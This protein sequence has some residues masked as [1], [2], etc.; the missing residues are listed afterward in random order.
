MSPKF[1]PYRP[2]YDLVA[3][4]AFSCGFY[5]VIHNGDL[6]A[7]SSSEFKLY[8]NPTNLPSGVSG[9]VFVQT[10]MVDKN[11]GFQELTVLSQNGETFK[12]MLYGGT[13]RAWK[14]VT[15]T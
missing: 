14:Q 3:K 13:W 4:V 8:E 12:R 1:V 7:V 9:H 10:I 15:L 6:N 5:G 2:N 11:S